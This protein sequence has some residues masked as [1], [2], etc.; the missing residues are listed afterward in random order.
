MET[1]ENESL[2]IRLL[3]E[4]IC[5]KYGYDFRSYAKA[6]IKRRIR[7]R[8]EAAGLDSISEMQ[9]RVIY[10]MAFFERL[11]L[12]FSISVTEMFRDPSFFRALRERVLPLLDEQPFVRIWHAGCATGEEVYSMAILLREA[13]LYDRAQIYATDF[14]E[15][16]LA[17]AREGIFPINRIREYTA[18]YQAAGGAESFAN[19]YVA[20]YDSAIMDKSLRDNVVFAA[21]NLVTDAVFNEMDLIVCRNV[22]IYFNR[23]LQDRVFQLFVDSLRDGGF[24]CIGSKETL[25]FTTCADRFESI[26]GR[27]RIYRKGADPAPVSAGAIAATTAAGV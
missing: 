7:R 5:L 20:R 18:N 13:G 16:V 3:L 4:A 17:Q 2:E 19:Y 26:G 24:L 14:N 8:L 15:V 21:H 10:D 9:H 25:R 11:L 12:D 22:L 27:E 23:E 1:V 6:S